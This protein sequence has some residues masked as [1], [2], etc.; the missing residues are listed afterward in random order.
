MTR[1]RGGAALAICGA[2]ALLLWPAWR[3]GMPLI[4]SD[5][6]DYIWVSIEPARRQLRPVAYGW[7]I[8]PLIQPPVVAAVGLWAVV[9]AQA[10][11]LAWLCRLLFRVFA[12]RLAPPLPYLA[13]MAVIAASTA[14]PWFASWL[15]PDVLTAPLV[16]A[17]VLLAMGGAAISR[18]E[19]VGLALVLVAS[20]GAHLTHVPTAL[21]AI[22]ALALIRLLRRDAGISWRALLG[23]T[24]AL[25]LALAL[26]IAATWWGTGRA[27]LSA[28][29]NVFAAAPLV[30]A[31]LVQETLAAT[32]PRPG[33]TLCAEID[34]LP[35]DAEQFLWNPQSPI[36]RDQDFLTLD[37]ELGEIVR[38]TL[39]RH[40]PQALA[41]GLARAARQFVTV[42][43]ADGTHAW[44]AREVAIRFGLLLGPEVEASIRASRQVREEV[45]QW[46]PAPL[47]GPIALAA[48]AALVLLVALDRA[49]RRPALLALL[50]AILAAAVANA[51]AV[52]LG[53]AVHD[54][55]QARIAWLFPLALLVALAGRPGAGG[56]GAS[57]A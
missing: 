27:E 39:A 13:A 57:R 19:R 38:A 17:I 23:A 1:A 46:Q 31:G 36:W 33:W 28:G 21:G 42:G 24:L 14:A 8:A 55:Y 35:R 49:T 4:F 32:C 9:A 6:A 45:A 37:P 30:A 53:G 34:R 11:L 43:A 54:R 3:N 7:L 12:P 47:A 50:A 51:V 16:L 44:L 25:P 26:N 52:G 5:A 40:W 22:T 20:A 10:L 29:A 15:M 56:S 41:N 48:L 2:A 18:R